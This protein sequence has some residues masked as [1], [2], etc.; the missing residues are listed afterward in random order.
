MSIT[1]DNQDVLL[2]TGSNLR[3]KELIEAARQTHPK[4]RIDDEAFNKMSQSR[5]FVEK[6]ADRGDPVYGLTTGVGVR[7]KRTIEADVM[8]KYNEQMLRDHATGQGPQLSHELVHASTIL[9]L[10]TLAAG[11]T[12]VRPAV[13]RYIEKQLCEGKH[14]FRFLKRLL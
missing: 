10:N 6:L 4:V 3:L 12:T 11:H 13:A 9:L 1:E 2:L 8:D 5:Q 14:I 7:K